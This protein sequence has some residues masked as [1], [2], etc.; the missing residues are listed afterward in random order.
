MGGA[1]GRED[2]ED[3]GQHRGCRGGEEPSPPEPG[4]TG[5]SMKN[6]SGHK[7]GASRSE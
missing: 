4:T 7:S 5:I 1:D 2:G 3:S 6:L